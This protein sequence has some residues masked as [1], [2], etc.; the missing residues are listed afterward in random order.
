MGFD[1]TLVA[2]LLKTVLVEGYFTEISLQY[3]LEFYL[4][5]FFLMNFNGMYNMT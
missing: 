1:K 2:L 4:I 3:M 5:K